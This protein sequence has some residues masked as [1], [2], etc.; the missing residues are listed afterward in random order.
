MD[1]FIEESVKLMKDNRNYIKE[2][3][4]W[5]DIGGTI[6]EIMEGNFKVKNKYDNEFV[7]AASKTINTLSE[8]M[9]KLRIENHIVYRRFCGSFNTLKKGYVL[10][11]SKRFTSTTIDLNSIPDEFGSCI[12]EIHINNTNAYYISAYDILFLNPETS[13]CEVLLPPGKFIFDRQNENN[14]YIF[15]FYPIDILQ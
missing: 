2:V 3:Y 7:K 5:I 12:M 11:A 15:C 8:M 1:K 4:N 14:Y 13:E 6:N 9:R 10:D